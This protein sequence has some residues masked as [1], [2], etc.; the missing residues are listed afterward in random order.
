MKRF[1]EVV[2]VGVVMAMIFTVFAFAFP[3]IASAADGGSVT[4]N[5]TITFKGTVESTV[6]STAA[7]TSESLPDTGGKLPQTGELIKKSLSISGVILLL[8][9]III[10][11]W[12]RRK[13][14]EESDDNEKMVP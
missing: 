4:S 1:S 6:E 3:S 5:G 8:I 11:L 9:A 13:K 14:D 10:V 2:R 12:R 7:S